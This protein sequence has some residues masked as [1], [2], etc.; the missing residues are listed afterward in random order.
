MGGVDGGGVFLC[1]SC[2]VCVNEVVDF[3]GQRGELVVGMR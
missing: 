2:L 3:V 1:E